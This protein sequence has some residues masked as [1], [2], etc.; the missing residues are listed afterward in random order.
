MSNYLNNNDPDYQRITLAIF[1]VAVILICWQ[2]FVE[3]PRRQ[4]LA[5][6][7]A[8]NAAHQQKT[9]NANLKD[10][11]SKSTDSEHIPNL[12]RAELLAQNNR[13]LIK[14]DRLHGSISLK[15]ARFDDL[16]L[17]KY[18]VSLDKE[19]PEVIL[20]SPNGDKDSYF[21]QTGWVATDGKTKVPDNQSIWTANKDTLNAN[22][23][24]TLTWN[25]GED[26]TFIMDISLNSDYMFTIKQSV[27]N[28]SEN[29]ISVSPY[30]YI[31]RTYMLEDNHGM[32][33]H[34]GPMGVIDSLVTEFPYKDLKEENRKDYKNTNGWLGITDKYWLT[35]LIP[36]D[37]KFNMSF[38]YYSQNNQDR[39]QTDYMGTPLTIPPQSEAQMT[40]LRLFAG[41]K[42]I[43]ILDRYTNGIEGDL[44]NKPIP[45]FDRAVDFG[46]LY[47]L[48]KPL[49]LML[50]IFYSFIGNFGLAIIMVTIVIKI[51][52]FPLA[53]KSYAA[54]SKI[55]A[56]Q[57]EITELK[58]RHKKDPQA[59][60]KA[61]ME[62]YKRHKVNPASGC[63]PILIQLPVFIALYKVLYVTIEMRHAP[64]FG[65]LKDLSAPDPSNIFTLF[66]M[67]NWDPPAFM[68]LGIL[69]ILY[70]ISMII[71]QKQQPAPTDP[72]QEKIMKMLPFFLLFVFA[73]FPAGLVLYWVA[74]NIFSIIQQEVITL[75]H[76]THRSQKNKS[77][78]S[79]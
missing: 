39:F 49:F 2:L 26:V 34:T 70:C 54:M 41:A 7:M 13:V 44:N 25:N 18:K 37:D 47:F 57:P 21:A 78:T 43:D 28:N 6:V 40:Q 62:L 9:N 53:N 65:W 32:I 69:P 27:E 29:V 71:Q 1:M 45:L 22:D 11:I 50:N 8:K 30:G 12:S 77:T 72:T 23:R 51:C 3:L 14:S 66:G 75:R 17:A 68:H 73:T 55:K 60:N 15:A 19:S 46:R 35:A 67:I 20:L 33:M 16:T 24:I 64:F 79:S 74:S 76:G 56:L 10:T 38:S 31:N 42:E 58:N 4:Q 48:T 61:M 52:M 36:N 59:M 5:E 63:L